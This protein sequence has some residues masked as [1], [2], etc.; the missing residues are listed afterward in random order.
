M[1]GLFVTE[2]YPR[3]RVV[4]HEGD[5]GDKFFIMVRGRVEVLKGV[6]G[7]AEKQVNRLETGDY[8]GEIALL[9]NVPRMATVR[10]LAPCVFLTLQR[11]VHDVV[12]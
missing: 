5:P 8:F 9:K 6:G 10:T 4:V 2:Q 11:G 3:N 1:A 7:N 12:M